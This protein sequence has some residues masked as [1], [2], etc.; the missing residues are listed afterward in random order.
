MRS[1]NHIYSNTHISHP[2]KHLIEAKD[3]EDR[4][5][6][7]YFLTMTADEPSQQKI[8]AQSVLHDVSLKS[9]W[10]TRIRRYF[11][12]VAKNERCELI[13]VPV[14]DCSSHFHAVVL[15]SAPITSER[16]F[17]L[18]KWASRT[19]MKQRSGNIVRFKDVS[20]YNPM[21]NAVS[22]MYDHHTALDCEHITSRRAFAG[23][24]KDALVPR[25]NL[26]LRDR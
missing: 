26:L 14:S 24:S 13:Y 8:M 25:L 18:W 7:R 23:M 20:I 4:Y 15:S 11:V 9:L 2:I 5:P 1:N 21:R 3:S 16:F 6:Y 12:E 17:N 19:T 10:T 22:Y